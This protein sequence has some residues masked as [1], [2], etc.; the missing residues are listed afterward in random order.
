MNPTNGEFLILLPFNTQPA[1]NKGILNMSKGDKIYQIRQY[2]PNTSKDITM[3]TKHSVFPAVLLTIVL[4]AACGAQPGTGSNSGGTVSG[5]CANPLYPVKVGDLWNYQITGTT[6]SSFTRTILEVTGSGFTDQ[7]TFPGPVT[8]TGEW[9]C[10]AGSLTSLTP[11]GGSSAQVQTSGSSS[12]F[13][14]NDL[15]GVTLPANIAAGDTWN[16]HMVLQGTT[17]VSGTTAQ[18]TTEVTMACTADGNE[19]VIAT[20]GTFT[21]MKVTCQVTMVIT[22]SLSGIS[23]PTN[24]VFATDSWY[25][26]GIGLVRSV[27][28]GENLDSTIDLIS[29]TLQ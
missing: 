24:L 14:T 6:S 26:P 17:D 13:Q 2:I 12:D 3:F 7:D 27:T 1:M 8:R 19:S 21:A 11:S 29:Y 25:A 4:L 22:I 23:V 16:Q 18:S 15:T 5:P 10:S 9:A 28:T 20:A